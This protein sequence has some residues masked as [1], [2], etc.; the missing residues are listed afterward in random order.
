MWLARSRRQ[1]PA[2]SASL[3]LVC[4]GPSTLLQ[5]VLDARRPTLSHD[6]P[7]G[8]Q[9][10]WAMVSDL[11]WR[12]CGSVASAPPRCGNVRLWHPP[13]PPCL[14]CCLL[15]LCRLT[16]GHTETQAA[17]LRID[18]SPP[19][20]RYADRQEPGQP[21]QPPPRNT[22]YE[23]PLGP[24]GSGPPESFP[25]YQSQG[26]R[27]LIA[28]FSSQNP[29]EDIVTPSCLESLASNRALFH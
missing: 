19:L 3:Q 7:A 4:C 15:L 13:R 24:T 21:H 29:F 25:S 27:I 10:T 11:P 20:R 26:Y 18:G 9:T 16:A 1:S 14:R 6:W 8:S 2:S 5:R 23:P 17:A 22:R 12:G 28:L